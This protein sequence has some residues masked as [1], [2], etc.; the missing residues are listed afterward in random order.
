MG[1]GK[2]TI[3][4]LLAEKLGRPFVDLDDRIE[5]A[6][7]KTIS[8]IFAEDGEEAFRDAEAAA[9]AALLADRAVP[10][11]IA[12]GGG[13]FAQARNRAAIAEANAAV[14]AEVRA[15]TDAAAVGRPSGAA[16]AITVFLDAPLDTLRARC[17][18]FTHRPLAADPA[19]F[20]RLYEARLPYYRLA[21]HVV[22][23]D[24]A[25]PEAAAAALAALL[26]S[27]L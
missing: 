7:G 22:S 20:K 27:D 18:G 6:A 5:A 21:S 16:G 25:T 13:A 1:S 17:E 9:L 24:T 14:D 8:Q 26:T 12:L 23:T 3:G 10:R 4:R 2:T 19:A 11:V 15:A